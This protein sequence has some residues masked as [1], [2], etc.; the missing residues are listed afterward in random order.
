MD[1]SKYRIVK[2]NWSNRPKLHASH[3]LSMRHEDHAEGDEILDVMQR[4]NTS[5]TEENDER[6]M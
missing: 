2:D 3:G 6:G 5:T 1:D 4:V